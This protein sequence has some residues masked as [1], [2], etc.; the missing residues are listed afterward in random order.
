MKNFSLIFFGIFTIFATSWLGLI[1]TPYLQ[2]GD[3][4][5]M[6]E[7][8]DEETL[9]PVE[10]DTLFPRH[11]IGAGEQGKQIY[12]SLGCV[13]CHTQQVQHQQ[14]DPEKAF[15][16]DFLRGYGKR[17][18]VARDYI[19]QE[20]VLIGHRRLGPDLMDVGSRVN[21]PSEI[22][23][24]LSLPDS[25]DETKQSVNHPRYPFLFEKKSSND[26]LPVPTAKA[27]L[28]ADYM[29]GLRLDYKLPEVE[30]EKD[31]KKKQA[32]ANNVK[33]H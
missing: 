10:G 25:D 31:K 14:Q 23:V 19:R 18:S 29:M 9:K 11:P 7:E 17:P 6:S 2:Y 8:I 20:S 16:H 22:Y 28:L 3:L 24:Y 5:T 13:A 1:L 26:S 32:E 15:S 33:E 30:W 21:H 27:A 12:Q 4:K